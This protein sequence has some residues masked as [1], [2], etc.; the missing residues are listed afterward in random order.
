MAPKST[1]R[2]WNFTYGKYPVQQLTFA[3]ILAE[4]MSDGGLKREE[5]EEVETRAIINQLPTV[6][7][8]GA[9][10]VPRRRR[11]PRLLRLTRAPLMQNASSTGK[12]CLSVC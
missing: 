2:W 4:N 10:S 12:R 8:S 7:L 9:V 3:A 6:H 11:A 1:T 5:E